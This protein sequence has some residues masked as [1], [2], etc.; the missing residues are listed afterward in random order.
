MLYDSMHRRVRRLLPSLPLALTVLLTGFFLPVLTHAQQVDG[1]LEGRVLDASGAPIADAVVTLTGASLQG[2]RIAITDPKGWYRFPAAPVGNYAVKVAH[3]T[4]QSVTYENIV[5]T[6]GGT[7]SVGDARLEPRVVELPKVVVSATG[8]RIDP[9]TTTG[10]GTLPART[11]RELPTDRNFRSLVSLIPQANSTWSSED[12]NVGS[13]TGEGNYYFIDGVDVTDPAIGGTSL[14]LPYDFVKAIEVKTG[15]YEAEYGRAL[16]GIVNVVTPS[17]GNEMQRQVFGYFTNDFFESRSRNSLF[18]GRVGDF[19]SYDVGGSMGGPILADKLWWFAAYN[20]TVDTREAP[21]PGIATPEAWN[22]SH[23]F[24]GKLTWQADSRTNL[25]L[26]VLGDPGTGRTVGVPFGQAD[27]PSTVLNSDAIVGETRDGGTAISLQGTHQLRSN[28]LLKGSLSALDKRSYVMPVS[29]RGSDEPFYIDLETGTASGGYGAEQRNHQ[30]RVAGKLSAS[31]YSGPHAFKTGVEYQDNAI[32]NDTQAGAGMEH[33]GWIYRY[34]ATTYQ[35][36]QA[37]GVGTVHTRVPTAF[38]QDSWRVTD[39]LRLNGGVRWDGNYLVDAGGRTA[40]RITDGWQPRAGFVYQPSRGGTHKIY[41]SAGR[42]YQQL[43]TQSPG[44]YFFDSKQLYIAYDHDPR[45]DP[46]GGDT[47]AVL[48]SPPGSGKLRGEH[49]DEVTL[50]YEREL[51]QRMKGGVRAVARKLREVVEDGYNATLGTFVIGNPGA[52]EMADYP[53]P[54]HRYTALEFTLEK[55]ADHGEAMLSY[56]W[57]R[58]VGNY[59]GLMAG[60]AGPQ[61]DFVE[62]TS[63]SYGLLS[64]DRPHVLKLQ[65]VYRTPVGFSAGSTL[66]WMSGVPYSQMVPLP[67]LPYTTFLNP[68][69]SGGRTPSL[70]DWNMRLAQT[71]TAEQEG[72]RSKITLDLFHI[73]SPRRAVTVDELQYLTVDSFGQPDLL[74]PN[75]GMATRYQ[76]A[77]T[78]R[79]GATFEF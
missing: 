67:G 71:L 1:S 59:P 10:G 65:G 16:G 75:Y 78:A 73:G 27:P 29:D 34:D 69:G 58:N 24:A 23:R 52:G 79:L 74:N 44:Y 35:W 20:P 42:F 26:T 9:A 56:V 32:T 48:S 17:G 64:N 46:T 37:Y 3:I 36:F 5:V 50:G 72:V 21:V 2:A 47:T 12:V 11:L 38:A 76:P 55:A 31:I 61:Y 60:N 77:F 28:V 25:N 14:N 43:P 70:W 22:R 8:P 66:S 57:S 62:T 6:L 40:L 51:P 49:Y 39:R 30:N 45:V 13:W 41:G 15:G 68:R 63:N 4:H 54:T 18:D 33:G 19:A 53:R 7:T